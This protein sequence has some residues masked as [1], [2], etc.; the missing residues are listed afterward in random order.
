MTCLSAGG[1][2][3]PLAVMS[4]GLGLR[5]RVSTFFF[6]PFALP[7]ALLCSIDRAGAYPFCVRKA[8]LRHTPLFLDSLLEEIK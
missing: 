1:A 8:T 2:C 4:G 6:C 7:C 5:C 3:S